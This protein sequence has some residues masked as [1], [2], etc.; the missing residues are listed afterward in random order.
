MSTMTKT[1]DSI[2]RGG[3]A[4]D[5]VGLPGNLTLPTDA[6]GMLSK[7][8]F[9][10][11]QISALWD[12]KPYS[13]FIGTSCQYASEEDAWSC[14]LI[15]GRD[16]KDGAGPYKG[17][18]WVSITLLSPGEIWDEEVESTTVRK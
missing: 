1:F 4:A 11:V 2:N 5:V 18:D 14:Y 10:R 17:A 15:N 3:R 7:S 6:D 9:W 12:T 13:S 8:E 16:A